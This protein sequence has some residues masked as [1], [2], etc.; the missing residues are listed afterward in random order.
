MLRI[1]MML[2]HEN[3]VYASEEF[4]YRITD[5]SYTVLM[6]LLFSLI[7]DWTLRVDIVRRGCFLTNLE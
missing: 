1:G 2:W 3:G 4:P 7:R 6:V 5:P